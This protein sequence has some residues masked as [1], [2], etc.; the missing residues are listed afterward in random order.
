M[1][2]AGLAGR[3][4][5]GRVWSV[6]ESVLAEWSEAGPLAACAIWMGLIFYLSAQPDLP[7]YP[8]G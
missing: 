8:E 5:G 7:H 1:S 3:G 4:R 6:E 2:L